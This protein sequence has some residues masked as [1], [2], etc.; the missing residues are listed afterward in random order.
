MCTL[1]TFKKIKEINM[2]CISDRQKKKTELKMMKCTMGS[3]KR[4]SWNI[5]MDEEL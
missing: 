1:G 3:G 4:P 2:E 5:F